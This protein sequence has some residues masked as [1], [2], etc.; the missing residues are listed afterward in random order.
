MPRAE[1]VDDAALV[2]AINE[3]IGAGLTVT[4]RAEHG[5]LGGAIYAEHPDGRPVV[6]TRFVGSHAD[7]QR[8]ADIVNAAGA[9]GLPVPRHELVVDLDGLVVFVQERLPTAVSRPLDPARID[10]LVEINDRF[11]GALSERPDVPTPPWSHRDRPEHYYD[12]LA[13][14]GARSRGVLAQI[15][16]V[17]SL[18]APELAGTDLVHVDLSAANVLFDHRGRA[19]AVIDWNLGAYRGDRLFALV[20]TRFDRE[21]FLRAPEPDPDGVAAAR[22]LD[23]ILA[24]RLAPDLLRRYWADWLLH[25]LHQSIASRPP[26]VVDWQLDLAEARLG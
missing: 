5:R 20:Q 18:G 24:D 19:T 4:G 8:V 14:H 1:P 21:W 7:A 10:A 12:V 13:G 3:R 26:E 23:E 25:H 22:H 15:R 9:R 6:L 2:A 16:H 11:A 17:R